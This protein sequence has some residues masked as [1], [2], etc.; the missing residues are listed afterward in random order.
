MQKE[1]I[2]AKE[3]HPAQSNST[4]ELKEVNGEKNDSQVFK[5]VGSFDTDSP[6]VNIAPKFSSITPQAKRQL[7]INVEGVNDQNM[8]SLTPNYRRNPSKMFQSLVDFKAPP[9]SPNSFI[10]GLKT[11]L[12]H[13]KKKNDNL[14]AENKIL[15]ENLSQ[16]IRENHDLLKDHRTLKEEYSIL[17]TN[18]KRLETA[19]KRLEGDFLKFKEKAKN[20]QTGL[21][22]RIRD[23]ERI[24]GEETAILVSF[25]EG[26][27]LLKSGWG[28]CMENLRKNNE[29]DLEEISGLMGW[30]KAQF[31]HS[32]QIRSYLDQKN[33][34]GRPEYSSKVQKN[35]KKIDQI[36]SK[37]FDFEVKKST[38]GS[39]GDHK[40]SS[41]GLL[42]DFNGLQSE[43]NKLL[44]K[45][46]SSEVNKELL[47]K[48]RLEASYSH[49]SMAQFDLGSILPR[50]LIDPEEAPYTTFR[51]RDL[52]SEGFVELSG[53]GFD[54]LLV[55]SVLENFEKFINHLNEFFGICDFG[56]KMEANLS[57]NELTMLDKEVPRVLNSARIDRRA[58][59]LKPQF[60]ESEEEIDSNHLPDIKITKRSPTQ[61]KKSLLVPAL[62]LPPA[63]STN[64]QIEVENLSKAQ[65]ADLLGSFIAFMT[66]TLKDL[67]E[68]SQRFDS[69]LER[70]FKDLEDQFNLLE[71][72]FSDRRA[73]REELEHQ[74]DQKRA[75]IEELEENLE[76]LE[77]QLLD[78]QKSLYGQE[79]E[80]KSLNNK[81]SLLK[82]RL[83]EVEEKFGDSDPSTPTKL[84]LAKKRE[85]LASSIEKAAQKLIQPSPGDLSLDNIN[86]SNRVSNRVSL[87]IRDFGELQNMQGTPRGVSGGKQQVLIANLDLDEL[88]KLLRIE[89]EKNSSLGTE[90][91]NKLGNGPE[92]GKMKGKDE[93]FTS[94]W[95]SLSNSAQFVRRGRFGSTSN[96][97]AERRILGRS[98]SDYGRE[99]AGGG[100]K[101]VIIG[102]ARD[103]QGPG[104]EQ[105]ET[106][107]AGI[108]VVKVKEACCTLI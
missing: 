72:S 28:H 26:L 54:G 56:I 96:L 104:Y 97:G 25:F 106:G 6:F 61:S 77:E 100:G 87:S 95:A 1:Q 76:I 9:K 52:E 59:T 60:C 40:K 4:N 70:T 65:K 33:G 14:E 8:Q 101:R 105:V 48:S 47:T 36:F 99:S 46:K 18:N 71:A 20:D 81:L 12:S 42:L 53:T 94:D 67:Q 92:R 62:K 19:L 107:L 73:S 83:N 3:P 102:P 82:S 64:I 55:S 5:K 31:D 78:K 98:E 57:K 7:S 2:Q 85:V 29:I 49:H 17:E 69:Y 89:L 51:K 16:K 74:I 35:L 41:G 68:K 34:S 66:K 38:E 44:K 11:Q 37:N 15:T 90:I 27:Q 22:K 86:F 103:Y 39:P 93:R 75:K 50:S 91:L 30:E 23:T 84:S 45:L 108:R 63:E 88:V 13:A 10:G 24:L 79:T 21:V 43:Y 32:Q 80:I 58:S